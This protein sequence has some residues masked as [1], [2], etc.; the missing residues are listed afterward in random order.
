MKPQRKVFLMEE[1]ALLPSQ[2][3]RGQQRDTHRKEELQTRIDEMI[4]Y[5][6]HTLTY[7]SGSRSNMCQ[8]TRLLYRLL[9]HHV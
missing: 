3:L 1:A 2:W 4:R 5:V 8:I 6:S 9:T 7:V